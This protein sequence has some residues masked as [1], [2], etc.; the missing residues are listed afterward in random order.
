MFSVDNNFAN[1]TLAPNSSSDVKVIEIMP[2]LAVNGTGPFIRAY[3]EDHGKSTQSTGFCQKSI[4][5][6]WRHSLAFAKKIKR[7]Q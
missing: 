3:M 4:F 7:E 2:Y 5:F 6:N 1:P